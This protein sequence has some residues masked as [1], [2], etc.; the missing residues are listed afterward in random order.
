MNAIQN[1]AVIL[2]QKLDTKSLIDFARIAPIEIIDL[3][4]N[5]LENRLP[6]SEFI[7]LCKTL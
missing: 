7:S 3:V 2:I 5:E 1:Q 4:L 6:E